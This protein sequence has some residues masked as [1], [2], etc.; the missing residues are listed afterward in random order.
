MCDVGWLPRQLQI[1]ISGRSVAPELYVALGVRGSFN[2][3]VGMQ[4]ATRVVAVNRDRDAEVFAG[5]DLGIVG[6]APAF[7]AALLARLGAGG[8]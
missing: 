3:M 5:A 4:R 1:G 8:R 6:D 7:A 2:H